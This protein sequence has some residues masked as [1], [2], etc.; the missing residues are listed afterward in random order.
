MLSSL[1]LLQAGDLL[2][3]H[4]R[5]FVKKSEYLSRE[6]VGDNVSYRFYTIH[7]RS[8]YSP[9]SLGRVLQQGVLGMGSRYIPPL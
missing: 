2:G 1:I 5:F 7:R 6:F 4:L 9:L 8:I 3:G